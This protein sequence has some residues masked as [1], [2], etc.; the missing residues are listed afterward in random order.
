MYY[1][2]ITVQYRICVNRTFKAF[3]FLIKSWF[4]ILIWF[5]ENIIGLQKT[6]ELDKVTCDNVYELR[7]HQNRKNTTTIITIVS[8]I[9]TLYFWNTS[10][11]GIL[12]SLTSLLLVKNNLVKFSLSFRPLQKCS[13]NLFVNLIGSFFLF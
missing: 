1:I 3:P 6:F 4:H 11:V 13:L 8:S 5:F 9:T 10:R 12:H 7:L 2:S